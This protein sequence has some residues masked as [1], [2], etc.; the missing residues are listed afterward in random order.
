MKYQKLINRGIKRLRQKLALK[1]EQ[2]AEKVGL[3]NQG[4][5][6]IERN[7]YQPTAETI[8]KICEVFNIHPVDLLMDCPEDSTKQELLIQ[9]N[10]ILQTY[11]KE[12]LEKVCKVLNILKN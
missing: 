3:S 5:S 2:F 11:S 4:L 6:N 12:N 9:I 8:D 10:A 7:K 1:Q